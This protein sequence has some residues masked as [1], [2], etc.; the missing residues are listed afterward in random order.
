[1]KPIQ[2]WYP[3][4]GEK[5]FT[6]GVIGGWTYSDK[7]WQGFLSEI[8]VVIDLEEVQS[9]SYVGGTFMQL[10]GPGVFMPQKVEISVSEDGENFEQIATVWNDVSTEIPDLLF[11]SFDTIASVKARYVR[12]H[13]YR[14]PKRGFIFLDEII[15]N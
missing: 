7:R 3:A 11:R 4:A 12:Y 6:D 14:S 1:M 13:A 2:E 15:V 9:I 10:A 5:T 8:D